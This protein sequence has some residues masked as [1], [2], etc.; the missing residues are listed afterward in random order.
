MPSTS[1][2]HSLEQRPSLSMFSFSRVLMET[3]SSK[4]PLAPRLS[5]VQTIG[6]SKRHVQRQCCWFD[7]EAGMWRHLGGVKLLQ[8]LHK[9]A[10]F[11][12]DL[13]HALQRLVVP[14][15]RVV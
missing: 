3:A 9:G 4:F 12:R 2:K 11:G 13:L 1:T 7:V 6:Q 8:G 10:A 5:C 14:R 15:C